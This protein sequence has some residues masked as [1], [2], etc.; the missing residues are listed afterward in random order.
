MEGTADGNRGVVGVID[1][2]KL[3]EGSTDCHSDCVGGDFPVFEGSKGDGVEGGCTEGF[4]VSD[5]VGS[6]KGAVVGA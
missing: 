2:S 3:L 4:L 1:G 6:L 5:I